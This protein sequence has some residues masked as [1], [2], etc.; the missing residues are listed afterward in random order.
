MSSLNCRRNLIL[1]S[2]PR[3][4]LLSTPRSYFCEERS[5]EPRTTLEEVKAREYEIVRKGIDWLEM[6]I[7]QYINVYVSK[8]QLDIALVKKC[9]TTDVPALNM[10]VGNLQKA[11]QRYVGF[12]KMNTEYCDRI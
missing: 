10:A 1:L 8:D 4:P 12:D 5:S 3:E 7:K 6:Q 2:H 9:K 11:L